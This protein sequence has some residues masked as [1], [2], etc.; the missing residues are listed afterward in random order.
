MASSFEDSFKGIIKGTMS[1]QDAFRN[2]LN[3]IAD[4]F[5]DMLHKCWLH[6]YQQGILGLFGNLFGGTFKLL[7]I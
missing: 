7:L 5:L 1:V 4:H 3:R 6:K 2:M